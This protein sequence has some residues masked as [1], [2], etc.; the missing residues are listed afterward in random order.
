MKDHT[1]SFG[2]PLL[3]VLTIG[4]FMLFGTTS[5]A[6]EVVDDFDVTV[7]EEEE[8]V[9]PPC[10]EC[11][12]PNS[13]RISFNAGVDFT[14]KYFFR[15]MR[16]Q[17][18]GR[19]VQPWANVDVSL[20]E[21]D[22]ALSSWKVYGGT[23]NSDHSRDQTESGP[24]TW[25]ETDLYAGMRF[26]LWELIELG[27][28]YNTYVSP[29]DS[30]DTYAEVDFQI[31]L[32]DSRWLGDFALNPRLR[33]AVETKNSASGASPDGSIVVGALKSGTY[34]E[35]AVGPEIPLW[36]DENAITLSIPVVLG[37]SL[38]NYYETENT[39]DPSGKQDPTFGYLQ[40]GMMFGIP[41]GFVPAEYGSWQINAGWQVA[42]FGTTLRKANRNQDNQDFWGIGGVSMS[43]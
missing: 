35:I 20:Y 15:G 19:I 42:T 17:D 13:G 29:N 27:F 6:D 16:Q 11:E 10:P 14:N 33:W 32:D 1:R 28:G 18:R 25:Y 22:G 12:V 4:G 5:R 43:Y 24:E 36:K 41:L 3:G 21:S 23:W 9:A 34:M 7:A 40:T 2:V 8:A 39:S 37:L 30:F 38:E 31:G 26:G